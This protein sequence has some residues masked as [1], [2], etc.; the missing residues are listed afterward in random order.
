MTSDSKFIMPATKIEM[1]TNFGMPSGGEGPFSRSVSTTLGLLALYQ[2]P[3]L[4]FSQMREL[5]LECS[6]LKDVCLHLC[7]CEQGIAMKAEGRAVTAGSINSRSKTVQ[8]LTLGFCN[9]VDVQA[10]NLTRKVLELGP[11]VKKLAGI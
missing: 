11:A 9:K 2:C 10:K 4:T 1:A 3:G 7:C 8:D 5:L 6:C